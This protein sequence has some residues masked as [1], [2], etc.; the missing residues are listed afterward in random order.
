ML[1]Y[2]INNK[3]VNVKYINDGFDDYLFKP[4]NKKNINYLMKRYLK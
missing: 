1:D 4:I 2:Q 3:T